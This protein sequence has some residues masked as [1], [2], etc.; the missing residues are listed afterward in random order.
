MCDVLKKQVQHQ[1]RPWMARTDHPEQQSTWS[2]NSVFK[3]KQKKVRIYLI[4]HIKMRFQITIITYYAIFCPKLLKIFVEWMAIQKRTK[5][6]DGENWNFLAL[7][8]AL[9]WRLFCYWSWERGYLRQDL[10]QRGSRSFISYVQ[11]RSGLISGKICFINITNTKKLSYT[12][13]LTTR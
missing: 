1:Q 10:V 7:F 2:G 11:S 4:L 13:K 8:R 9:F 3:T 12:N 6:C 5:S